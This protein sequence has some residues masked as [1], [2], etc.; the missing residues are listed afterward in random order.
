MGDIYQDIYSAGQ[1]CIN[2]QFCADGGSFDSSNISL[3]R[4]IKIRVVA[5]P[6]FWGFGSLSGNTLI[7]GWGNFTN[8]KFDFFDGFDE[9]HNSTKV[10]DATTTG[11][12]INEQRPDVSYRS[13]YDP[14][15]GHSHYNGSIED[16]IVRGGAESYLIDR[17]PMQTSDNASCDTTDPTRVFKTNPAGFGSYPKILFN[18]KIYKNVTGAWRITECSGCYDQPQVKNDIRVV[19]CSGS[20]KQHIAGDDQFS[21]LYDPFQN[22]CLASGYVSESG[23]Q[24][25]GQVAA[26]YSGS[27]DSIVRD[28]GLSLFLEF[29]LNYNNVGASGIFNGQ[30]LGINGS[31]DEDGVVT[32][33][34]VQHQAS[35]TT[36]KAVGTVGTTNYSDSGGF[37]WT[38]FNTYDPSTCCGGAAYGIDYESKRLTNTPIYHI[39][40]GRVFNNPKNVFYSNRI[41]RTYNGLSVDREVPSGVSR[42]DYSYVAVNEDGNALLV[43]SGAVHEINLACTTGVWDSTATHIYEL[44]GVY[45]TE[46][47]VGSTALSTESGFYPLFPKEL[48]YF[49]HFYEVDRWD[50]NIRLSH[51]GNR[52]VNR[53]TTCYTKNG[54]LEVFPDCLSQWTQYTSCDPRTKYA[55]NN[56]PRIGL[57]YKGCDFEDPCTFDDSGRPWTAGAS[58]HP[59][60]MDDL[61]R[62]FGGQE[63]QMFINLGDARAAEIKREPCC[64]GSPPCPGTAVPEFVEV[65][66]P[67]TYP[68]FPKFDLYPE[69]YGCQ[70]PIY[71]LS[72][73]RKLGLD[74]DPSGA[75]CGIPEYDACTPTQ[76][77][78]TYGYIRNLCGKETNSRRGVIDSLSS[79]LHTGN[80]QD[81]THTDNT[82]EPMY[83]AFEQDDPDCC[84]P[85]G[86]PTGSTEC[87]P[88]LINHTTYGS[89]ASAE[90][91]VDSGGSITFNILSAG[92]GYIFGGGV[93]TLGSTVSPEQRFDLT[94]GAAN[95]GL[96]AIS[97]T[98]GTGIPFSTT[99]PLTIVGGGSGIAGSGGFSYNAC[100]TQGTVHYWGLTDFQGRL[101][102]PYFRTEPA[103]AT[104]CGQTVGSYVNFSETGT[105]VN[106]WPKDKVPFLVEIDHEEYCSSCSTTQMPT[107]NLVLTV[108]SLTTKY[109]HNLKSDVNSNVYGLYGW[110]HC[111][112]PGTK[113]TPAYDVNTDSWSESYCTIGDG[114][115]AQYT[116]PYTGETCA[117]ADSSSFLMRPR[118]LQGTN[119]PIGYTTYN[120]SG[121]PK[122]SYLPFGNCGV[123]FLGL[124]P[125]IASPYNP[126]A[127]EV[128]IDHQVYMSASLSCSNELYHNP[129]TLSTYGTN[130]LED[131]YGCDTSCATSFPSPN[132]A[133]TLNLDFWFV[134]EKYAYI[135]EKLDDDAIAQNINWITNGLAVSTLGGT[136][137]IV[138]GGSIPGCNGSRLISYACTPFSGVKSTNGGGFLGTSDPL[139]GSG[140]INGCVKTPWIGVSGYLDETD[141]RPEVRDAAE[142]YYLPSIAAGDGGQGFTNLTWGCLNLD[143]SRC[144]NEYD[145]SSLYPNKIKEREFKT[146]AGCFCDGFDNMIVAYESIW[147]TGSLTWRAN[148]SFPGV[149]TIL[150]WSGENIP[151]IGNIGPLPVS[152]PIAIHYNDSTTLGALVQNETDSITVEPFCEYHTGPNRHTQIGAE[153]LKP[154]RPTEIS[155]GPPN[156]KPELCTTTNGTKDGFYGSCG[157]PYPFDT[158]SGGIG[159]GVLVNKKACWPEIM[160]VHKIEC[161]GSGYKLHVSREYFEHDRKWYTIVPGGGGALTSVPRLGLIEGGEDSY[162]RTCDETYLEC[163]DPGTGNAPTILDVPFALPMITPT[164]VVGPIY[165]TL[166][167]TGTE[168]FYQTD[169]S[170]STYRFGSHTTSETYSTGCLYFPAV[171]GEEFWSFYNLL[172]DSGDPNSSYLSQA[173]NGSYETPPNPDLDC[174]PAFP[175]NL[176][177]LYG[178]NITPV[179]SSVNEIRN[180]PH[181]CLQDLP[182]CGGD[183]WC[184]KEFFPRRRYAVNTRITA[185]GA[186]SI[187]EQ[188][189]Q[190][191]APNW[192]EGHGTTWDNSPNKKE[193]SGGRFIDACDDSASVLAS[194]GVDINDNVI[195]IPNYN[196]DGSSPSILSLM[197]VIHPGFTRN[198]NQKTCIYADSGECLD[199]LPEH[200]DTTIRDTS[201]TTDEYGYYLDKLISSGS[202]SCLFTPFKIMVDVECCPDRI[203]HKGTS[204]PTNLNYMVKVPGSV[205][206]GWVGEPQCECNEGGVTPTDTCQAYDKDHL[207]R[208]LTCSNVIVGRIVTD[209]G[210]CYTSCATTESGFNNLSQSGFWSQPNIQYCYIF[211]PAGHD[212]QSVV[213]LVESGAIVSTDST[214]CSQVCSITLYNNPA[215]GTPMPTGT[216]EYNYT[217]IGGFEDIYE[218]N[219]N[220]FIIDSI[221]NI[222]LFT[223]N[224]S[225]YRFCQGFAADRDITVNCC[226]NN[227]CGCIWNICSDYKEGIKLMD[228]GVNP[229]GIYLLEADIQGETCGSGLNYLDF[230]KDLGC[231]HFGSQYRC[232]YSSNLLFN[233]TESV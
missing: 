105:I 42:R 160:T 123:D 142:G 194:S 98:P 221:E 40:I 90:L 2:T 149:P 100:N 70:D 61:I 10:C 231:D 191:E 24:A 199:F 190:L 121:N 16:G 65:R 15:N 205:C 94:F 193:L 116:P 132:S 158:Y 23:C 202:D 200:N 4:T 143:N 192:Y 150:F 212:P 173:G 102:V 133:P 146:V 206:D 155:D 41:D 82:V 216:L 52:E 64:C 184:N 20:P 115:A 214:A 29:T 135:F 215:S 47:G 228:S 169:T 12:Y 114:F 168:V 177:Q 101:A 38:A 49:G 59:S 209:G 73:M 62:G 134:R 3:P 139:G 74:T 55:L 179:F 75:G 185:F 46:S 18:N 203:G 186:L 217:N 78:T 219:G 189:A 119:V 178:N 50:N 43:A 13:V 26:Q 97:S 67:V 22:R 174:N 225:V 137:N 60:S 124:P 68:C 141:L 14:E 6:D 147:D 122:N 117:C 19:D 197:G 45:S 166:C 230:V 77:Y 95:N 181:S 233:I 148:S 127:R 170:I 138:V 140:L 53:N 83:V 54:S 84:S 227:G 232:P 69:E 110:N 96:S 159:S 81:I 144:C 72:V 129:W 175:H 126:T 25:D 164:D 198:V 8:G 21:N 222:D 136:G 112:Y 220:N 156:L 93:Y 152:E 131:I 120:E 76:P 167:A 99:I 196:Q 5:N 223:Y 162:E 7:E 71:Y 201:F 187:C 161:V 107:G 58:G 208:G 79:N 1:N 27:G 30:L 163:L 106:G 31:Q 157:T 108:N 66:S 34:D 211:D 145:N 171:S 229:T 176:S 51:G 130:G 32:A 188:N 92:S 195:Y 80:Y 224:G 154:Y 87:D 153:L 204:S 183:L 172:Y 85:S 113:Y 118:T 36:F 104:V 151:G 128:L 37:T 57:V 63:I 9:D 88:S 44:N 56:V 33:F 125:V 48:P 111:S 89:G 86:F 28:T 226:H 213:N 218:H 35:G 11:P 210:N 182:E 109:S 39:D 207:L 103:T 17:P 91:I 180:R 165:P